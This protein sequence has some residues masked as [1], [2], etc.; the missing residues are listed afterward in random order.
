[1]SESRGHIAFALC[2]SFCTVKGALEVMRTLRTEGWR[3]TPIVSD[4]IYEWDTRFT[5]AVQL[6][7]QIEEL[8]G[9][10][11]L[12]T[13]PQAEPLGPSIHPD[14]LLI[15]PC[16]GNT[17]AK[18][19]Q[20]ITDNAVTMAAKAQ[21]RSDRPVIIGLAS[22]DS[23]S[24]NLRNIGTLLSRKQV[25]FIPLAQDDPEGKPHS[26]IC[27]FDLA[28]RTLYAALEGKQLQPLLR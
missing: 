12:H 5:N 3:I 6:R 19:A 18:M 27:K 4:A 14:A 11:I 17:L 20:G 13:V 9:E 16:T 24:A 1:M 22:N 8:C 26:L 2:G 28:T 21:L 10:A 23:L 7:A 25:Y 15:L